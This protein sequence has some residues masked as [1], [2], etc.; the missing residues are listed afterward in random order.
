MHFTAIF[1]KWLL[2][3]GCYPV[4]QRGQFVNLAF[5]LRPTSLRRGMAAPDSFESLDDAT[6]RL[7]G[8]MLRVFPAEDSP[9][10][11][12]EANGF[13][14]YVEK[15]EVKG[16]DAGERVAAEGSLAVDYYLWSEFLADRYADAPGLF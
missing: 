14:C 12:V 16:W 5:E 1:E 7:Y 9:V 4:L 15:P 11:V 2:G 3:D 10:A 13:R 6:C 8:T